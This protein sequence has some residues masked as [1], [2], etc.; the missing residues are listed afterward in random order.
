MLCRSASVPAARID[1]DRRDL[2]LDACRG[3]AL[4]FIFI[5]HIPNNPVRCLS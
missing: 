2:R 5:D 1:G 3:P 4:W